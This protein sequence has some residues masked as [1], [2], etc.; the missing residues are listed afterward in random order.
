MANNAIEN[1]VPNNEDREVEAIWTTIDRL[2]QQ[3]NEIC[4]MLVQKNLDANQ[5]PVQH[6][7]Y[8]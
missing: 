8:A 3:V 5:E 4:N 1:M 7:N 2:G 6:R